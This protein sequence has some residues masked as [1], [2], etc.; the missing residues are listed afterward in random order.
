MTGSWRGTGAGV[1][2]VLA[3]EGATV[4]VHGLEAG[5]T[6]DTLASI[7]AAGGIAHAVHGDIRTDEGAAELVASVQAVT[8]RVDI[9]VNNYGVAD[10]TTWDGSDGPS[11]H[12]QLRHQRGVG[13]PGHQRPRAGHADPGLGT[14]R[15]RRHG[16]R[17][18][19]R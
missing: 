16:R 19:T 4:L 12:D 9:L 5:T 18:P 17:H 6:R 3:A 10:G 8:D 13:D 2:R 11:W 7:E 15:V 1:A 14:H